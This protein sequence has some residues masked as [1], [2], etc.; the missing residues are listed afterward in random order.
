MAFWTEATNEPKRSYRFLV[1]ITGLGADDVQWW[2]KTFKVPSYSVTETTHNFLD[3]QY[4]FPGRVTWEEVTLEL[5]DPQSPNAVQ[6][7][8]QMIIDSGY[9]IKS[10][11]DAKAGPVTLSKIKAANAT[12]GAIRAVIV[13]IFNSDGDTIEKWTLKNPWLKGVT[14]ADLSYESDDLRTLTVTFRYDWAECDN[15]GAGG[16]EQFKA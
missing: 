5:V 4:H 14:F 16:T 6:L 2:A 12:S 3:N 10:A 8:N 7:T 15:S 1:Q 9:E 11:A 13:S